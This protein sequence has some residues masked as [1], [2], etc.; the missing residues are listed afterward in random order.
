MDI[1]DKVNVF[2]DSLLPTNRTYDYF[3]CWNNVFLQ[4]FD[5]ELCS[6]NSLI[7]IKDD[8]LFRNTFDKLLDKTPSVISVFPY[9]IALSKNE[10]DGL[11]KKGEPL[12]IIKDKKK[13]EETDSFYFD[14]K[15]YEDVKKSKEK[16]YAFFCQMGLKTLFQ[17]S[18]KNSTHDYIIG[19]L[20]GLD[21]NGR[22]NRGGTFFEQLC[23]GP[24][25]E[26]CNK[27]GLRFVKQKSISIIKKYGC[28]VPEGYGRKKADFIVINE[29]I[30]KA[31][32]IEVNFYNGTGSKPEEI[33]DAYIHRANSFRNSGNA[34]TLITDGASCWNNAKPQIERGFSEINNIINYSML[35]H[36]GLE[37]IIKHELLS[38]RS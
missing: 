6:I 34:F 12:E 11:L 23:E 7:N 13:I 38:L 8:A 4:E 19:V 35:L 32:N 25:I 10:R 16:Y 33:I 24:I 1:Q 21:S 15:H 22:K 27:Y 5:I 28:I 26:I 31:M 18:I 29:S 3:V 2:L 36:N 17:K 20:V 37:D 30:S 14:E 9:L